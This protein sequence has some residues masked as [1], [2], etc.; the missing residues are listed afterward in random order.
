MDDNPTA[1]MIEINGF[2]LDARLL[3]REHQEEAFRKGLIPYVPGRRT[4]GPAAE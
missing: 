2:V 4:G 3:K 1:W